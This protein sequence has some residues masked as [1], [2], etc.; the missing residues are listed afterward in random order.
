MVLKTGILQVEDNRKEAE[1]QLFSHP[2][3]ETMIHSR[4]LNEAM[5]RHCL[6][7]TIQLFVFVTSIQN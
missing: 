2:T 3:C 1:I 4:L 7:K 6:N 5:V